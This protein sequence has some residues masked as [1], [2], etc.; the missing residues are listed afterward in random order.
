[1]PDLSQIFHD[2]RSDTAHTE[3]VPLIILYHNISQSAPVNS[4]VHQS[5]QNVPVSQIVRKFLHKGTDPETDNGKFLL[6]SEILRTPEAY[7]HP[8]RS[9]ISAKDLCRDKRNL[10]LHLVKAGQLREPEK[11]RK[12]IYIILPGLVRKLLKSLFQPFPFFH[13]FPSRTQN[14]H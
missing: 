2:K 9:F 6:I 14:F 13:A 12:R 8:L 3:Y 5:P 7:H 4:Q 11:A 10:P 1:M